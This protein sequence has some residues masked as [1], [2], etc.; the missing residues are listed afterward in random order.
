MATDPC[1]P[2]NTKMIREVINNNDKEDMDLG[3]KCREVA[4]V[5]VVLERHCPYYRAIVGAYMIF[6]LC[7]CI[8]IVSVLPRTFAPMFT[9]EVGL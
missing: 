1:S 4:I 3:T 2:G 9:R 7:A 6:F 8:Q 5:K